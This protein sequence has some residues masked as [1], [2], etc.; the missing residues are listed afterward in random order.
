MQ[1][2]F[3]EKHKICTKDSY[4]LFDL[5][6]CKVGFFPQ[7]SMEKKSQAENYEN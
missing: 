6:I 7:G 3:S 4:D 1:E 2:E 5:T